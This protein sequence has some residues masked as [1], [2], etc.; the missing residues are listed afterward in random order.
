MD[1]T[2]V[3][4]PDDRAEGGRDGDGRAVVPTGDGAD[5]SPGALPTVIVAEAR[6][7]GGSL[8]LSSTLAALPEAS[9]V[10][11]HHTVSPEGERSL[12]VSVSGADADSVDAA[13]GGDPTATETAVVQRFPDCLVC[14]VALA[15]DAL[16]LAPTSLELGA[17]TLGVEGVNG[18]WHAE[19]QFPD[20]EGLI[21]L[22][23][24]CEANG[25]SFGVDRLQETDYLDTVSSALTDTQRETLR[26]AYHAGYYDV[27]RTFSQTDLAAELG[28]STSAVSHRLRRATAQ[29]IREGLLSPGEEGDEE[30]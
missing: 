14:R 27:P 4:A 3:G 19:V 23:T 13:L 28:V 15:A 5:S 25:V 18:E 10:P 21:A 2:G 7:S 17:R 29:L 22:R 20:R 1:T 9:V 6:L 8:A 26:T 30:E 16:L 12:V 11:D 24:F